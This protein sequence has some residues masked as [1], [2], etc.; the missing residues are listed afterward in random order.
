MSLRLAELIDRQHGLPP[1]KAMR[2]WAREVQAHGT[3]ADV[4]MGVFR[5]LTTNNP[6]YARAQG[7]S[8]TGADRADEPPPSGVSDDHEGG[9]RGHLAVLYALERIA[10]RYG[11][12]VASMLACGRC[13]ADVPDC[14][15]EV[16]E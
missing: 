15:C 1:S 6:A 8:R 12:R 5:V 13:G 9:A 7:L 2:D 3:A 11:L 4:R 14:A 16:G 10:Y